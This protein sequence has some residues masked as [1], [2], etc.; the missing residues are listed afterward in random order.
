MEKRFLVCFL[1]NFLEPLDQGFNIVKGDFNGKLKKMNFFQSKKSAAI[2]S[3][4]TMNHC[5]NNAS[6]MS[7]KYKKSSMDM[8]LTCC[9]SSLS[10]SLFNSS[11]SRVTTWPFV[12]PLSA[13]AGRIICTGCLHMAQVFLSPS[14]TAS[15]CF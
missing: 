14:S 3:F 12:N 10:R 11:R 6:N 5:I 15:H 13:G 8:V 2:R 9:N 1:K 7:Q 4:L